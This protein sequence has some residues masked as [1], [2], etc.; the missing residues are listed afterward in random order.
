MKHDSF[1]HMDIVANIINLKK[2]NLI[3]KNDV[4]LLRKRFN[5]VGVGAVFLLETI[6]Q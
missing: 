1:F 4:C 6:K 3:V 5:A 2:M